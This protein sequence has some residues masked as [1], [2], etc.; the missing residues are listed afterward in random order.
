VLCHK[1]GKL[2]ATQYK[3]FEKT[4][5][6]FLSEEVKDYVTVLKELKP[7]KLERL[8]AGHVITCRKD[9]TKEDI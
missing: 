9:T 2:K 3:S 8:K 4:G 6:V 7:G 5:I 1:Y